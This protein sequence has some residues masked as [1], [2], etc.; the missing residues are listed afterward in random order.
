MLTDMYLDIG[1]RNLHVVK[2]GREGRPAVILEA[3][4]GCGSEL[5]RNVQELA[6][7]FAVT[8]SYDRAQA[9]GHIIGSV[10]PCSRCSW[11]P[12]P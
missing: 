5:W 6:G 11:S 9:A 3:G 12:C 2:S 10:V 7:E 1:G 8:Y 4:S